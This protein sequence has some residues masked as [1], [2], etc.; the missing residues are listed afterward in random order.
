MFGLHLNYG[1]EL[2]YFSIID[3]VC[4]SIFH[5]R[6]LD[7]IFLDC[8]LAKRIIASQVKHIGTNYSERN[9]FTVQCM[10][11]DQNAVFLLGHAVS[12]MKAV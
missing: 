6:I 5:F 11:V 7:S 8:R 9:R 3:T 2:L 1:C 4:D 12:S 10:L